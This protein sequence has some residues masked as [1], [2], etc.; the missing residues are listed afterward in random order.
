VSLSK[1]RTQS[2]VKKFFKVRAGTGDVA[3]YDKAQAKD[4]TVDTPFE[5]IVLDV[6]NT[7]G[8]F[9]EPTN[10]GIYSN[11]VRDVKSVLSVRSKNGP[12]I[13]GP[14]NQIKDRLKALGGRFANSVYIAYY[15]DG[16]WVLGNINFVGASVSE[17]F[18]FTKGKYL[19]SDPGV[20][21]TG[22]EARKK[23]RTDYF[24][25]VFES[26]TVPGDLLA[27]ASELDE[28][29]QAYLEAS[30]SRR[31]EEPAEPEPRLTAPP[32][33][34]SFGSSADIEGEPPF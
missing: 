25:P 28:A 16:A 24:V 14:Y 21:I 29:L 15:E 3:Y 34:I 17:W 33:Q 7:V 20:A 30:L 4:I 13:E 12:L 32:A 10:S 27:E 6:L 31:N 26:W 1:P 11:E 23:G 19:D 9:H 2:P 18:D 5:F 8:G 22:F